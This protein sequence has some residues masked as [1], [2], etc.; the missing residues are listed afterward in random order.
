MMAR[1]QKYLI[2]SLLL[3]ALNSFTNQ[4]QAQNESE[5]LKLNLQLRP[6]AEFRNGLFTPIL[7]GQK[8][9]SFI[10]Q[11][12]RIGMVYSKNEKLKI[13]LTTQ[14]V[15]TWGNDPQVQTTAN[16]ISVYEAWAQLYFNAKWNLKIGRQVFSYDDERILGT[17]DWNNAGRKHDAALLEF[18]KEK[19]KANAAFAFNQNTERVTGTF[20]DNSQSQPYKAMEFLW[21]KYDFSK[22]F[23]ASAIFMNLDIQNRIDSSV[24]HLQTFG[25]NLFY[26]KDKVNLMATYYY[27]SGN[28]PLKNTASIKTSAWMAAVKADYNFSKK[29]GV[30]IGSD[31]LTGR[32]MNA[33][34]ARVTS[35]NTLYGTQHKFYGLM[36]YFYS[37][38]AHDNVGL[39]DSYL[40]FYANPSERFSGQVSLHHFEAPATIISYSGSKAQSSLGNEA[41]ISIS[42]SVMKDVKLSGGY[43]EMFTSTSMKYVKNVLPSQTMKSL[44]NWIWISVNIT[45]SILIF[46]SKTAQ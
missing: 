27:Q 11:R 29:V 19:F 25:G 34:S 32:D 5:E 17:L 31:Y 9:A 36:D 38:S 1:I 12:S 2:H 21:M 35:F 33:Q 7:E 18:K 24:A 23:S 4:L 15:T 45:P 6:R 28:N 41:D 14:V 16:D 13:G 3:F 43:S 8:P 42:Y 37:A 46:K 39:W 22:A 30:G 26:K 44:Q 40:N 20:Y 10:S